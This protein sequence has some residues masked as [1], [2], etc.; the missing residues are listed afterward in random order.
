[1]G[2]LLAAAFF[3]LG[4]RAL[5]ADVY[6]ATLTTVFNEARNA[7]TF[8]WFTDQPDTRPLYSC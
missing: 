3:L 5:A 1:M 7:S 2:L 4:L 6:H 8:I